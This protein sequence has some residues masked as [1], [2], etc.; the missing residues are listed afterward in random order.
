LEIGKVRN[1]V[2]LFDKSGNMLKPWAFA[3]F[4]C[5]A[6]DLTGTPRIEKIENGSITYFKAD[7]IEPFWID[8]IVALNPA[9]LFG[10]PP[11]T[12]LAVSGAKH[13]K[14]KLTANSS[15]FDDA[16]KLVMITPDLA[17]R[18]G[19]PWFFENPISLV[20]SLY[21][22]PDFKFHPYE[23]GGYLPTN[24]IHPRHPEYIAARDAYS[25]KT[26]IWSGNG[27]KEPEKRIIPP[28]SLL[29]DQFKKLGGKSQK[30]KDIR[31]E[32]PRGFAIATFEANKA[33]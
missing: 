31:S 2:S 27:F 29:S 14:R 33:C 7:L 16:M 28:L 5:Y 19:C 21:R 25:K 6:F 20:S 30:T 11:C 22:K 1:I 15:V 13:F 17:N 9:I 23:Y 32:T 3:G 10:F 4:H 12:D 8:F 24:D 26:C 18:I